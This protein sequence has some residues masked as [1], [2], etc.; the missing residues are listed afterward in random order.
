MTFRHPETAAELMAGEEDATITLN[1]GGQSPVLLICE[2]AGDRIPRRLATLGLAREELKRHIA[3]DIGAEQV[4]RLVAEKLDAALVLQRYSR[5]V[6][7]CNRPPQ[8]P[9][10][11][12]E[13]S[14]LTEI[15]GNRGLSPR[16][17]Q[18]RIDAIYRP[19]HAE[20]GRLIELR[21]GRGKAVLFVTIHSFTP[22]FKGVTR[23]V[24]VGLLFDRDRRLSD[25]IAA[26]LDSSGRFDI[27]FN[28]P[29]GPADGV[30][31]TL[32]LH[33]EP[34]RLPY[35][36]IELRNDLILTAIGQA[37]WAQRLAETLAQAAAE[38]AVSA[39][40]ASHA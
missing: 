19:F 1:E 40:A 21:R 6:Y 4:A 13:I 39:D 17:R 15:P 5:L 23:D 37:E 20:V 35:A 16:Q 29:Y 24:Q 8:S 26:L 3:Y 31:H 11:I 28:E 27:R 18:A 36:M 33:A 10:A 14:E 30:C 12:P 34:R 32:I 2:H 22:V 38:F 7:D 9:G 25:R